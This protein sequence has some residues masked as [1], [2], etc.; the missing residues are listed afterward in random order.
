MRHA[1]FCEQC[2]LN[3]FLV[4]WACT[5]GHDWSHISGWYNAETGEK[6]TPPWL[7]NSAV[8]TPDPTAEPAPAVRP[9]M[10]EFLAKRLGDLGLTIASD[11]GTLAV[12]RGADYEALI[13]VA[14][15]E[16]TLWEHLSDGADPGVRDFV[17][18]AASEGWTVHVALRQPDSSG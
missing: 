1:G 13:V 17:R 5:K 6:V 9:Q 11:S 10:L 12:A 14:D 16:I 18:G 4:D 3:V 15:K 7:E 2:Q 8:P